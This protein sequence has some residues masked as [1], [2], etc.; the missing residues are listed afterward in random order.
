MER[1]TLEVDYY[2]RGLDIELL[3]RAVEILSTEGKYATILY[4]RNI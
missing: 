1:I 2:H 3:V 4:N